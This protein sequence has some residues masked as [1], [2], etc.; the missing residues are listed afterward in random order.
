MRRLLP[1]LSALLLL[2]PAA[3]GFQLRGAFS[4]PY[5]TLHIAQPETSELRAALK[6]QVEAATSTRILEDAKAAQASLQVMNDSRSKDIL[7]LSSAGRVREFQLVRNFTFRLVDAQGREIVA[8]GTIR[9]TREITFDDTRVLAKES[10]E[11]LLWKDIEADI[12]QQLMR[13]LAA[14]K[15]KPGSAAAP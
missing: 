12:V 1:A 6:R 8:P 11:A 2:L 9:V 13:R 10:E 15:P 4:L 5:A 3:C 14:A 7:S